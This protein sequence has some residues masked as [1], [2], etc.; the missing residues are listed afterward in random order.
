MFTAYATLDLDALLPENGLDTFS[1]SW[2]KRKLTE[3]NEEDETSVNSILT[4][5]RSSLSTFVDRQLQ[6]MKRWAAQR[7]VGVKMPTSVATQAYLVSQVEQELEDQ[8]GRAPS[9]AEVAD[10]S[11]IPIT[12]LRRIARTNVPVVAE[13]QL[14]NDGESYAEAGDQAIEDDQ[15]LAM[16]MTYY[17]LNP[18]NQFI[19]ERTMGLYGQ[20]PL[21]NQEIARRLKISPGAVSQRKAT[22]QRL[23]D[24]S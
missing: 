13:R 22:I 8:L 18:I 3:L 19:M 6:P 12:R 1:V 10:A 11:G 16:Q 23:I 14:A 7:R 4:V 21:S 2:G 20:K 24:Q 15:Q 5:E 9:R 17:S